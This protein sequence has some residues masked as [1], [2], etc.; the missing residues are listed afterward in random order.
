MKNLRKLEAKAVKVFKLE[1]GDL[2]LYQFK[3]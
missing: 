2:A 3:L 1:K